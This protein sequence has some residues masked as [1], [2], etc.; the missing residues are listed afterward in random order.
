MISGLSTVD[1]QFYSIEAKITS[2]KI[3]EFI[4]FVYLFDYA[5][6]LSSVIFL[7]VAS[8]KW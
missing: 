4:F 7:T 6:T 2:G 8:R 1:A 3:A 5:F